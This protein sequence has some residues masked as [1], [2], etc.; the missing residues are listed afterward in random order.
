M[1]VPFS[2]VMHLGFN[3]FPAAFMIIGSY[4]PAVQLPEV[5]TGAH[6]LIVLNQLGVLSLTKYS[7]FESLSFLD[8]D[9]NN[10]ANSRHGF[11]RFVPLLNSR[12]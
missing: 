12:N 8:P 4:W 6:S 5:L 11:M 1:V 7:A 9:T 2:I 3:N 10:F